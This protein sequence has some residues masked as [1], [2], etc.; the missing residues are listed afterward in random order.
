V[1]SNQAIALREGRRSAS[2]CDGAAADQQGTQPEP[3]EAR[4]IQNQD[5]TEIADRIG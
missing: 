5:E 1:S 3:D 4:S 2:Q